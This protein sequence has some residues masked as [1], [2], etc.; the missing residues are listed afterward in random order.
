[1][2]AALIRICYRFEL[3][4]CT[5]QI[6]ETAQSILSNFIYICLKELHSNLQVP[7]WFIPYGADIKKYFIIIKS[8]LTSLKYTAS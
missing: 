6:Y 5:I 2:F 4:I 7:S 8:W 1:M 3:M